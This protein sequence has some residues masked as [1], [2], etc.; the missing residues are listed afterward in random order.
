[1]LLIIYVLVAIIIKNHKVTADF[2]FFGPSEGKYLDCQTSSRFS[3]AK[4][5]SVI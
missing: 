2:S 4:S 1:M 3:W 5:E